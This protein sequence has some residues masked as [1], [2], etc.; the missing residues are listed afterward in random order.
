MAANLSVLSSYT[1]N[2]LHRAYTRLYI[3]CV[4]AEAWLTIVNIMVHV[5]GYVYYTLFKILCIITPNIII[6]NSHNTD[7]E[8]IAVELGRREAKQL[9]IVFSFPHL[10]E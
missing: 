5:Q 10:S 2:T 8:N 1:R 3:E 4:E 7:I 9:N 6:N